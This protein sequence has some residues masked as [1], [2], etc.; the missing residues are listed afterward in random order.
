MKPLKY[1]TPKRKPVSSTSKI[2]H[3]P[4]SQPPSPF[5]MPAP[6]LVREL[7]NLRFRRQEKDQQLCA[8]R[9]TVTQQRIASSFHKRVV[10]S[11]SS[12]DND[13][14]GGATMKTKETAEA[15]RAASQLAATEDRY[16]ATALELAMVE[17][18]VEL[19][20]WRDWLGETAHDRDGCGM[21]ALGRE[22]GSVRLSKGRLA[23]N[24]RSEDKSPGPLKWEKKS[25][26]KGRRSTRY[27]GQT[28][29]WVKSVGE[30]KG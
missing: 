6:S 30:L 20:H 16:Q 21:C 27:E 29:E 5:S 2:Y 22:D 19:L 23:L 7:T 17:L 25:G 4:P 9:E 13:D 14:A 24:R 8:L 3:S 11:S 1:T 10:S 26:A 15:T 28:A 18:E 12:S